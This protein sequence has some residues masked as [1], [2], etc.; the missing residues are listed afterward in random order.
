MLANEVKCKARF[1]VCKNQALKTL[2]LS[3]NATLADIKRRW[4][5]LVLAYHP[6]KSVLSQ[7]ESAKVLN[8]L[9]QARKRLHELISEKLEE[10]NAE[11]IGNSMRPLLLG[12]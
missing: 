3:E 10:G 11:P 5:S 12:T 4:R 8:S 1:E 6:D 2:G 7:E 9:M